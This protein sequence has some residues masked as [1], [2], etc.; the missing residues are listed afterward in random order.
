MTA[1][2]RQIQ[3]EIERLTELRESAEPGGVPD[4]EA[5][6][7]RIGQL[8]SS[9]YPRAASVAGELLVQIGGG[10]ETDQLLKS[11]LIRLQET[12]SQELPERDSA[13]PDHAAVASKPRRHTSGTG[14]S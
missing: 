13:V 2:E 9:D 11:G 4:I 8:A 3:V 10:A 6:L 14:A 5:I 1:K 7:S 12:F